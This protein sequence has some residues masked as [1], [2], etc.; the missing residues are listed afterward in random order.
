M[1]TKKPGRPSEGRVE[2]IQI[3]TTFERKKRAEKA[4]T[5]DGRSLTNWIEQLIDRETNK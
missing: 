4:A 1:A 5:K 3:R 2:I